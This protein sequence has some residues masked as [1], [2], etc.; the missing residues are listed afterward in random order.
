MNQRLEGAI[1]MLM[2]ILTS[3]IVVPWLL[4]NARVIYTKLFL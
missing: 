4:D 2:V 3:V 1:W